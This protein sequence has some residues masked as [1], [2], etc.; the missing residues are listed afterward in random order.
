MYS[1]MVKLIFL[2]FSS[3]HLVEQHTNMGVS[4]D[5]MM[6]N[7]LIKATAEDIEAFQRNA[8]GDTPKT[9]MIR[10]PSCTCVKERGE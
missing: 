9:L 1:R 10:I 8:I 7:R 3:E 2:N 4:G 5:M 6:K